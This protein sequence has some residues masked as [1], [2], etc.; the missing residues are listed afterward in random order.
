VS[1]KKKKK[2]ETVFQKEEKMKDGGVY[3]KCGEKC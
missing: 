2:E 3:I 1:E